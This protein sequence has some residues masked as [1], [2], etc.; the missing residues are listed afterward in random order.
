M[1]DR[2]GRARFSTDAATLAQRLLG[3]RLVR[4]LPGG[5]RL[6]AII[7]ETE[8][9]T[10][11][12]DL[13][14]HAR[15]G[16][17]SPRNESIYARP[18]TAYVYLIYG[19]HHCFNIACVREGH[20]GAVLI[21]AARPVEGVERMRRLRSSGRD[22]GRTI[23]DHEIASGPGR[24][25]AAMAIDRTLDG[26]DLVTSE[27][28]WIQTARRGPLPGGYVDN[29]PRVGVESAGTWA[30]ARLRWLLHE[31][32]PPDPPPDQPPEMSP[33]TPPVSALTAGGRGGNLPT[34]DRIADSMSH[35]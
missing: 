9:Y 21:R 30:D 1:D 3:Q 23:R 25:C 5:E 19:V 15:N 28:V 33:E 17:R 24:L 7:V 35:E 32:P 4:T 2:W 16:H 6:S 26:D 14:S 27:R 18:G 13:A 10:G 31:P 8:A 11:P 29:T 22:A 12:E 34:L 20:P